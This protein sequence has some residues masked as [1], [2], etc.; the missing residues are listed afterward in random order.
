MQCI[1]PY[2]PY[3]SLWD[4]PG[5]HDEHLA[6]A[7]RR[8]RKEAAAGN[9]RERGRERERGR[10]R[11]RSKSATVS[12]SKQQHTTDIMFLTR[13]EYDRGV[14]TFSPEGRW[15][16]HTDPHTRCLASTW[17]HVAASSSLIHSWS[18]NRISDTACSGSWLDTCLTYARDDIYSSHVCSYVHVCVL[19]CRLFQVEYAM[20]AIKLGST[21]V[22]IKTK[23]GVVLA[24]EKRITSPLLVSLDFISWIVMWMGTIECN[25]IASNCPSC[26]LSVICM[27]IWYRIR[28]V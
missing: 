26:I 17:G 21:A 3:L 14:N 16:Q 27:M 18:N 12:G 28:A 2:H 13:S 25:V 22:G 11:R 1:V 9:N 4:P 5:C 15:A 7:A 10:K 8:E 6:R 24:V 20:E 23:E 19:Y